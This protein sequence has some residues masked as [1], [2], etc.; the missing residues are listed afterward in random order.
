MFIL[1][2]ADLLLS[3]GCEEDLQMMAPMVRGQGL[4]GAGILGF[5]GGGQLGGFRVYGR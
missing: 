3:Y 1:D 2:E 4:R 5:Y